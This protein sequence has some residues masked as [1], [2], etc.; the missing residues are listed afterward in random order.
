MPDAAKQCLEEV[1]EL[2]SLGVAAV[3]EPDIGLLVQ[4]CVEL[5]TRFPVGAEPVVGR[6]LLRMLHRVRGKE[7]VDP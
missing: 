2:A 1:A 7:V 4:R 3:G 5:L 6:A